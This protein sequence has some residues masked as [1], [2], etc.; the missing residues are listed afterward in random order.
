MLVTSGL[1]HPAVL[2]LL[3]TVSYRIRTLGR[4]N[5]PEKGGVLFVCNHLSFV[6]ALLL[7]ASTDRFIRFLMEEQMYEFPLIKPFAR[8][9]GVFQCPPGRTPSPHSL[10]T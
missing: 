7:I 2:W 4:E 9:D 6:D 1:S 3:T 10:V 8:Y 5:I